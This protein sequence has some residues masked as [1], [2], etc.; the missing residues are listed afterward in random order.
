MIEI[1]PSTSPRLSRLATACALVAALATPL[2]ADPPL[3]VETPV[4][5]LDGAVGGVAVDR[6][7][8][9]YVADFGEKV[10]K[11]SPAGEVEVLADSLYGASGNAIDGE[12][13]LLQSS[14]FGNTLSRVSRDGTVELLAR[15]LQGPVGVAVGDEGELYVCECRANR[16]LRLGADGE[17]ST[18][19]EGDLFNCPNGITRDGDGNLFVVNF[20]D[21]RMLRID[22]KGNAALFATIPGGGN[23][24]VA[25][26][27]P[28]LYVTGFRANRLFRVSAE[29]EVAVAAGDGR[30][31]ARDGEGLEASFATPNGVAY[32][33]TRDVLFVNDHLI[34]FAQRFTGRT[35][36]KSALRKIVFPTL[37]EV[38][39]SAFAEGGVE[40][41]KERLRAYRASRPGLAFE[42]VLNGLG[43]GF[44]QGGNVPAAIAIFE[45]NSEFF[46]GS[47]NTWDSLAEANQAAG[48][49][50]EA[51]RLYRKSLELN[52]GNAN[53]I[54]KLKELGAD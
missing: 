29:G 2:W 10:W 17:R 31:G 45:L 7:G 37:L 52:P 51:I 27:G 53:A 20:S 18:F 8:F 6:L 32:D 34:P 33:R 4:P 13:R 39:Q 28:D 11:I 47:F 5:D 41:A 36:P 35:P 22:A 46:P 9:V 42:P 49:P 43:Y 25:W 24:H 21:G 1:R 3:R 30:F 54:A 14:F 50:K 40:E 15:D 12:G 23:G 44:L 38:A 19:A 16:I 48:R 26:I